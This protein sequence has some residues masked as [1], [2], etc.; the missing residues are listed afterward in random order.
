MT[1]KYQNVYLDS[2]YTIAG[3]YE[4]NGPLAKYFDKTFDTDLYFDEKTFE[5]AESKLL[6]LSLQGLLNKTANKEEY[7]DLVISGDLQNQLAS[8]DY[9]LRDYNIPFLGIFSACSTI[10]EAISIASPFLEQNLATKI[11]VATS[12]HNAVSEKQFRGPN[13]YGTL[14]PPTATFTATGAASLLLT[15]KKTNIKISATTIGRV[16]DLGIKDAN[17]M[18]AVMAPAAADTIYRHLKNTNTTPEDYDLILTGDLGHYGKNI[19]SEY[20]KKNYQITIGKNYNDCGL[21]LYDTKKQPVM[22]GASGPVTSALVMSTYVLNK[23][24]TKKLNKVLLVP[25]GAI[26]SPTMVMEKE[27][28][29]AISHAIEL[30]RVEL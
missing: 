24:K 9:A 12:S 25:T 8:S 14:K 4:K 2:T 1:T 28:I 6:S 27:T 17:N 26:F 15:N 19:L 7:I 11:I 13:E 20:M 29:P 23:L 21:I 22:A 30:E 18:G 16:V 3:I 10:S 5:K